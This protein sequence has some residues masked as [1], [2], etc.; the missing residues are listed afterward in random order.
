MAIKAKLTETEFN[1]LDA[2]LK[3]LYKQSSDG[4]LLDAEGVEDVTGLKKV[5]DDKKADVDKLRK[6]IKDQEDRMKA[7]EGIDIDEAKTL[8]EEKRKLGDK[9]MLEEGKVEELFLARTDR[10][11]KDYERQITVLQ[12]QVVSEQKEKGNLTTRL[13]EVLIDTGLTEAAGKAGIR[14]SA[15]RDVLLRGRTVWK[16]KDGKPTPYRNGEE[17]LFGKDVTKP[18]SM[19]E[20]VA[21]LQ[22]DAP[23]LFE[24]NSGARTEPGGGRSGSGPNRIVL[25]RDQAR[26]VRT[27]RT[28][29]DQAAKSGAEVVVEG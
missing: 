20:W 7:F 19:E 12:Q 6:A 2:A 10:L 22:P 4:F 25:T 27:W 9:K 11:R 17:I 26:D 28:A 3:T 13:E 1:A 8:I 23:H 29:Q 16:L 15:L 14:S 18:I 24:P 21:S 5:L